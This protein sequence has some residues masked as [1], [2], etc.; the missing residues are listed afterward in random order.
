MFGE[1][2]NM[3]LR[4]LRG[5]PSG[6]H[7]RPLRPGIGALAVAAGLAFPGVAFP[8]LPVPEEGSPGAAQS[9]D[10]ESRLSAA[11]AA[12]LA[13]L[14][15]HSDWC[16][17]K[18]V[19]QQRSFVLEKILEIAPEHEDAR[20]ILGHKKRDGVWVVP[21]PPK[22]FRDRDKS[23][24]DEAALRFEAA[25]ATFADHILGPARRP[26]AVRGRQDRPGG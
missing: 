11:R 5:T 18:K 24:L 14:E 1:R 21:D 19:L 7:P 25:K 20:R 6:S 3:L 10:L 13:A 16:L 17:E 12:L 23:V 2:T 9:G 8:D 26:R 22:K 4:R 15:E